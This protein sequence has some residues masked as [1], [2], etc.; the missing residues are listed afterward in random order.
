MFWCLNQCIFCWSQFNRYLTFSSSIVF[1]AI[2]LSCF[3]LVPIFSIISLF[4]FSVSI[5]LFSF[6]FSLF[7]L[8]FSDDVSIYFNNEKSN[9]IFW[10]LLNLFFN[11]F[12]NSS[13]VSYFLAF[14]FD[15]LANVLA[16]ALLLNP[17]SFN[18]DALFY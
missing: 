17:I 10:K 4:F 7:C 16:I 15:N 3:I 11:A 14:I 9:P 12:K 18:L 6:F 1:I 5:L 13:S 2:D 8:T